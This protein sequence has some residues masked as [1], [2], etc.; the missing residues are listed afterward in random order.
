MIHTMGVHN[1]G[2]VVWNWV[3]VVEDFCEN[4]LNW[5]IMLKWYLISSLM[6]FWKPFSVQKPIN[7]LWGR[8]TVLGESKLGFFGENGEKSVRTGW[9]SL[10]A[11]LWRVLSGN[12]LLMARNS[13]KTSYSVTVFPVSCSSVFFTHF[14]FE[15]A[16]DVNMKVLDT[17]VG[18]PMA[19]VW[20]QNDF[21]ILSYDENNP[22]RSW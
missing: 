22:R 5:W 14:C 16:F 19:L 2:F 3:V 10:E 9:N 4:R 1:Y 20:H 8:I 12:N 11:H 18:F 17:W 15:L 13:L 7:K 21:W 6:C